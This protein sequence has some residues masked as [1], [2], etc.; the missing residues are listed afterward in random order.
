MSWDRVG[1][2]RQRLAVEQLHDDEMLRVVLLDAVDRADVGM[3][4]RRCGSCFTL[5]TLEQIFVAR[6]GRR[7]K[8]QRDVTPRSVSS[9]S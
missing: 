3:V 9:A 2:G 7:E 1:C 5:K 4:E 6:Q 8:F